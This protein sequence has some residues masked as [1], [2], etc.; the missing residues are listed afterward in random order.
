MFQTTNSTSKSYG[1]QDVANSTIDANVTSASPEVSTLASC[2]GEY[3]FVTE[4]AESS[5]VTEWGLVCEKRYLSFLGPTAYYTGVLLGAWIAG[6]LADR[7]GRLP[8]QAICLYA[9]GTMA[10]ALYIVQVRD[11]EPRRFRSILQS[12]VRSMIAFPRP[13]EGCSS[14]TSIISI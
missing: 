10:V 6:F 3:R 1:C 5:V 13:R 8:V 7:I 14:E 2:S 4:F 11:T 12:T 9:Q